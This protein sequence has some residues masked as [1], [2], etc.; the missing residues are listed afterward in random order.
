[1]LAHAWRLQQGLPLYVE[2]NP[3]FIPFIYPP[4]Y[5]AILALLGQVVELDYPA[6][7]WLSIVGTLGAAAA[8]VFVTAR[9]TGS[10]VGGI[11]GAACFLGLYRASGGFYD[12]VRP[13]DRGGGVDGLV[14]RPGPGGAPGGRRWPAAC[15]W[16]P[17]ICASTTWRPSG[18]RW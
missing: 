4:G 5:S 18:C 13:D 3:D 14:R 2:P 17:P 9:Q 1:M 16:P 7:R 10:L 11:G 6:G 15:C 8:I 12:L